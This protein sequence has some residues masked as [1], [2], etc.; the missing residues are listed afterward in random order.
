MTTE[1]GKDIMVC[2]TG[3]RSCE[4]LIMYGAK[5]RDKAASAAN[6]ASVAS[7]ANAVD[8]ANVQGAVNGNNCPSLHVVHCALTGHNFMNTPYEADAIEYLFTCAQV[9]GAELSILRADNAEE[10]LSHYAR[11]KKVGTIVMGATPDSS[12]YSIGSMGNANGTA[13]Q[14]S[15]VQTAVGVRSESFA[16]KLKRRLPDVHFEVL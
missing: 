11:A 8:A 10:A 1:I 2:V 6:A 4:R 13:L 7:A 9:A 14:D 5:L 16:K 3:Q 15:S 12:A